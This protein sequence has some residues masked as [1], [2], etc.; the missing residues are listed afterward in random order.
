MQQILFNKK[1]YNFRIFNFQTMTKLF[2]FKMFLKFDHLRI[3]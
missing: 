3:V 1:F 2:N